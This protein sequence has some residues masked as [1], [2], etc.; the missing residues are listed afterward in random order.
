MV[1]KMVKWYG[2]VVVTNKVAL[3]KWVARQIRQQT[4]EGGNKLV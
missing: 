2:Y 4:G 1:A 3:R